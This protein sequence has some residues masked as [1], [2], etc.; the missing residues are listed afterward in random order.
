MPLSLLQYIVTQS[1]S[2]ANPIKIIAPSEDLQ[3]YI[4]SFVV[5][6]CSDMPDSLAFNDGTPMLAFTSDIGKVVELTDNEVHTR[7]QSGWFST[8]GFTRINIRFPQPI[9]YLLVIR[10]KMTTFYTIWDLNAKQFKSKAFWNLDAI[11][12]HCDTLLENIQNCTHIDGKIKAI[13]TYL[14]HTVSTS[15]EKPNRLL[16]DTLLHIRQNKGNIS[17]KNLKEH[18]NV[19]YKWLE[20]S[21]SETLGITPKTYSSLQRFINTY[22]LFMSDKKDLTSIAAVNGYSDT[23]HFIKDFKRYIGKTPMQYI[24]EYNMK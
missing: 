12:P 18:F 24:S 2:P 20:R 14:R 5:F 15:K 17:I 10:F 1:V 16:E 22:A 23:S 6:P 21:Y 3:K 8:Q 4:E 7:L 13:E 19:N 11:I 9:S